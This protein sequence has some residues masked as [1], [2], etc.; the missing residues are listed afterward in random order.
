VDVLAADIVHQRLPAADALFAGHVGERA[1]ADDRQPPVE[2]R[3]QPIE[4]RRRRAE[5]GHR[6]RAGDPSGTA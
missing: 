3:P 2:P 4:Q 6:P 1:A 5:V